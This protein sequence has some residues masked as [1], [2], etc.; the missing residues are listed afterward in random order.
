MKTKITGA[1]ARL[2]I[3]W[4]K[5]QEKKKFEFYAELFYKRLAKYGWTQKRLGFQ[6]G[7]I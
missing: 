7:G 2:R 4:R 1:V 5:R 6:E 3:S